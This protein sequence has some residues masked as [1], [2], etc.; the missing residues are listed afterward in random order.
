MELSAL[1]WDAGFEQAF[2]SW[3]EQGLIAAR[4]AVENKHAYV[5]VTTEGGI[6]AAVSGKF[7]HHRASN[8]ELPKVGDWVA[9]ARTS[10]EEKGVI[11]GVLPRRTRLARKLAGRQVEEQVLAA[12]VD[13]AF[14]VQALDQP[15]NLRRQERFL[16]MVREGVC[17]RSSSS[18][19]PT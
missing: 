13:H 8:A 17:N 11:H 12:N 19:R 4:V 18:T 7:L 9:V 16:V 3:H 5:V 15:L 2:A 10:G 6:S 14:I 1:G